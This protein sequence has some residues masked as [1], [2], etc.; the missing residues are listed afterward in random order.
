MTPYDAVVL[1]HGTR[2]S[3]MQGLHEGS[4][5]AR[6]LQVGGTRLLCVVLGLL[7]AGDAVE[8][9]LDHRVAA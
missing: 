6:V 1:L 7:L 2:D 5:A 9:V 8:H 4:P 3:G